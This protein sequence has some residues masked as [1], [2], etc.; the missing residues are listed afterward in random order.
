MRRR[1]KSGAIALSAIAGIT[2]GCNLFTSSAAPATLELIGDAHL[3]RGDFGRAR[4]AYFL[5]EVSA[6]EGRRKSEMDAAERIAA[7]N[8]E[9]A[10]AIRETRQRRQQSPYRSKAGFEIFTYNLKKDLNGDGS[11][12]PN[13]EFIGRGRTRFTTKEQIGFAFVSYN[14]SGVA[15]L[16][17]FDSN[18]RLR[19]ESVRL[20]LRPNTLQYIELPPGLF[21]PGTCIGEWS[22][23]EKF[24]GRSVVEVVD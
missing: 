7:S 2:G 16:K 3:R 9:V 19:S 4:A 18:G 21:S 24:A 12:D 14:V 20:L 23:D 13:T 15:K 6:E 22:V 1:G 8:R 17:T 10:E 5:S 11:I